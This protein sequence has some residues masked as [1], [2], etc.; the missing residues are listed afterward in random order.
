M[1]VC[2][3]LCLCQCLLICIILLIT[4]L[5]LQAFF[6]S[7]RSF[8]WQAL[9][10]AHRA[11]L[12]PT[13][14]PQVLLPRR[15]TCHLCVHRWSERKSPV[16]VKVFPCEQIAGETGERVCRAGRVQAAPP[17][18]SAPRALPEH[19]TA[20]RVRER[21]PG[22]LSSQLILMDAVI[23]ISIKRKEVWQS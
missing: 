17:P 6:F 11:L 20:P 21:I 22:L 7:V 2:D 1:C 10:P 14:P 8:H 19:T 16:S 4:N 3:C 12:D 15:P 23:T 5:F 18:A 9:W 13:Q